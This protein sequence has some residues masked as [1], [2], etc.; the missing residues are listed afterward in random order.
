MTDI[1]GVM[2]QR[3]LNAAID[4]EKVA[5]GAQETINAHGEF[6]KKISLKEISEN[7]KKCE[8]G[9]LNKL[10]NIRPEVLGDN[11]KTLQDVM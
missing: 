9:N 7:S 8:S 4:L 3:D 5:R 6:V 11:T 10:I 1:I 2:I